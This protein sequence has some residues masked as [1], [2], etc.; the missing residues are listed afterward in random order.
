[1]AS[2]ARNLDVPVRQNIGRSEVPGQL[3][4]R[5]ERKAQYQTIIDAFQ[6]QHYDRAK[7]V[8]QIVVAE[9]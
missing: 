8:D 5:E 7:S 6:D 1:L 4:N 3:G 9:K 2:W